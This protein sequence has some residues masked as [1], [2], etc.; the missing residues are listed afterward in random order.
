[1]HR[2]P[3]RKER[4]PMKKH[5]LIFAAACLLLISL[6]AFLTAGKDAQQIV[7]STNPAV[8][9]TNPQ[10]NPSEMPFYPEQSKQP[11]WQKCLYDAPKDFLEKII[12]EIPG[13]ISPK[14]KSALTK[15]P[16]HTEWIHTIQDT[17][18]DSLPQQ[19][20]AALQE[21]HLLRL[22]LQEKLLEEQNLGILEWETYLQACKALTRWILQEHASLLSEQQFVQ[23]FDFPKSDIDSMAENFW[24]P[25]VESELLI[26]FPSLQTRFP[27]IRTDEELSSHID[28]NRAYRLLE[29]E[30][31]RQLSNWALEKELYEGALSPEEYALLAQSS[32]NTYFENLQNTFTR[33]EIA[34]FYPE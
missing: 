5:K 24:T 27:E 8:K 23:L 19:T 34:F 17:L 21:Q 3:F 22:Y 10:N 6:L 14:E 25:P 9:K 28:L 11:I 29:V 7:E 16:V 30:K 12:G 33:E 31:Q 4:A 18:G 2:F 1:M 13:E 20:A 26:N 15:N 32:E